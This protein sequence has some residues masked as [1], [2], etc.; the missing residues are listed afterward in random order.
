MRLI[1]CFLGAIALVPAAAAQDLPQAADLL[2]RLDQLYPKFS[3]KSLAVDPQGNIYVAGG[4]FI[5]PTT[6]NVQGGFTPRIGILPPPPCTEGT[7]DPLPDLVNIR[8]GPLGC[9]DVI[10]L[11]LDPTG[12][13]VIYGLAMGGGKDDTALGIKVDAGGNVYV[14]GA[15]NSQNFPA[16]SSQGTASGLFVLKPEQLG[17]SR[18]QHRIRLGESS[19]C[20]RYRRR[21]CGLFRRRR[22]Q[23]KVTRHTICV[24]IRTEK[25]THDR[26]VRRQIGPYR[27]YTA[28]RN[29]YR[30]GR[31]RAT[32]GKTKR[33]HPGRFR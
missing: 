31:R 8:I 19:G 13:Q 21:R 26:R 27:D 30:P 18:L 14:L 10:V 3:P 16:T 1:W 5:T 28:S 12:K 25:P 24:S 6:A 7:P 11:K 22:T 20:F 23:R 15:F 4:V 2:Q 29:L 9:S 17:T 32:T 33:R